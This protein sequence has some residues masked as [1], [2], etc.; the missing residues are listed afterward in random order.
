[1]VVS[2]FSISVPLSSFHVPWIGIADVACKLFLV[3]SLQ[4][5]VKTKNKIPMNGFGIVQF[6]KIRRVRRDT[7]IIIL[8]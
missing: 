3:A 1:M 8:V 2:P 7:A 6:S 5:I 4:E